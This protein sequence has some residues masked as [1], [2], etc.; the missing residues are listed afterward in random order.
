MRQ[1]TEML[2]PGSADEAAELFGDG[3]G[4]T[5]IGGGTIVV[6]D[7]TYGRT[8]PTRALL[9][10]DAGLDGIARSGSRVT[11]GATTPVAHL[12][13]L[14]S[15]LGPCAAH[16]ADVEIRAQATLGGNLCAR[17]SEVPRG[18]LQGPLLALDATVRSAGGD[19]IRE[20]ALEEFLQDRDGRLVLDV[21][22]DEPA[23]GAFVALDRPHT[24]SYTALAISA[25]RSHDGV[26]RVAITGGTA[27]AV[28]L[29]S[30]ES[31]PTLEAA[32]AAASTDVSFADDAIASAWYRGQILPVLVSRVLT[33]LE[34]V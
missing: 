30:V 33:T 31:A 24:H 29:P 32:V 16:I 21:S 22:F 13:E 20:Q 17:P 4:V 26:L 15:P 2:T 1:A 7:I 23:A 9:L 8:E 5:V 3:A 34:E 18:D 6:S 25:A 10:Q 27:H 12:E 19:G 28:R 14:F 11:I